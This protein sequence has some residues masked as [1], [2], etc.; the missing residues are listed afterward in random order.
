MGFLYNGGDCSNSW[1]V[2]EAEGKFFCNDFGEGPPT[3]LGARSFIVVTDLEGET[4]FHSDYVSVGSLFTLSD[5]GD[6]FPANQLITIY[7]TNNTEDSDGVLQLVQYHSSCSSNLF[8]KDRFGASQLVLWVNEDQGTVSC[9]ANQT[10]NLD[11][12]IPIDIVGG[13][14]TVT[15]LTVASNVDPYFFNLT[16]KIFGTEAGAGEII[17]TSI[18][19]PIDLSEKRTYTLLI[20][21]TAVTTSGEQC[22]A[23]ELTGFV[24]GYPLPPVFPTFSPTQSPENSL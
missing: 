12:T 9:F 22:T 19:I 13:P 24:A 8:L 14:A 4:I 20:T 5:G 16:E 10:F 1:N 3:E 18:A 11:I 6:E 17:E 21:L 23:T 15:G 7:K 2:Q